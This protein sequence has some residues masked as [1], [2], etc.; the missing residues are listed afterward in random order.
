M[1]RSNGDRKV[2]RAGTASLSASGCTSQ[3]PFRASRTPSDRQRLSVRIRSASSIGG[4]STCGN[5]RSARSHRRCA[6]RLPVTAT[7]PRSSRSSSITVTFRVPCQPL[8][9]QVRTELSASSRDK[10]GPRRSSSRS[11]YLRKPAFFLRNSMPRRSHEYLPVRLRRIRA[12]ISGKS[13]IGRMNAPH[14]NSLRSC[15]RSRSSS[16]TSNGPSRL[17]RTSRWGVATVAIGSI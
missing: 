7:W 11:T 14:S 6:P 1:R 2:V 16:A 5:Q 17:Q 13:S 9:F 15:Q 8:D 10:R 12:R 3:S 4:G